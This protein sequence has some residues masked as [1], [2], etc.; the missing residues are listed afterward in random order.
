MGQQAESFAKKA[1]AIDKA[2]ELV[3]YTAQELTPEQVK[4]VGTKARELFGQDL[5]FDFRV[6]PSLLA[7]ASLAFDGE[8]RDYSLKGVFEKKK[9]EIHQIYKK[10]L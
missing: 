3:I 10:I 6:D 2:R 9:E 7:G 4:M 1:K 8:Y 5:F